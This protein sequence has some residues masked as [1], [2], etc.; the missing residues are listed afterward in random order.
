M[1]LAL[2][3]LV[4]GNPDGVAERVVRGAL[5]AWRKKSLSRDDITVVVGL[6]NPL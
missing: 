3:S 4:Q 2:A 5:E 6:I 1:N